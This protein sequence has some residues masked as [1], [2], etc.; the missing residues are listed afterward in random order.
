VQ[1]DDLVTRF[2]ELYHATEPGLWPRLV[3]EGLYSTSAL[4]DRFGIDGPE[5]A[6]IESGIRP[7][8]VTIA[9]PVHGEAIIHH[10]TPLVRRH[11][12]RSL[13]GMSVRE[14]CELLNR[15]VFLWPTLERL[16]TLQSSRTNRTGERDV[17]VLDTR[18]VVERHAERIRLTPINTGAALYPNA[19]RRGRHTFA[20]IEAYPFDERRRTRPARQSLAEV[21]VEGGIP[22]L[23]GLVIRVERWRG[24]EC[25]AI[26]WCA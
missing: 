1:T 26:I 19:A 12:E 11:L 10:Q 24:P 8:N 18:S 13:D 23:A 25:A 7:A 16:R 17:L 4:L 20:P 5:R 6:A 14:W 2:P 21:A 3:R 9:H 15:H 22:D